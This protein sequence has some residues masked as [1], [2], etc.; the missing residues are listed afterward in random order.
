MRFKAVAP[1]LAVLA[2]GVSFLPA[3]SKP[4]PPKS[5]RVYV[6]DLGVLDNPDISRY[7]LKRD[8]IGTHLMSVPSFLISTNWFV[9]A[10]RKFSVAFKAVPE[11]LTVPCTSSWS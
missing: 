8:E 4:Q 2:A 9:S 6:F 7:S 3:Q 10:G 5:L 11:R 1:L